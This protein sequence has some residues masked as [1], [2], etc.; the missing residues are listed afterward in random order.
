MNGQQF[1]TK[2]QGLIDGM[3]STPE[4][5][6]DFLTLQG[7]WGFRRDTSRCPIA[8]YITRNIGMTVNV[9]TGIAPEMR[10]WQSDED[11]PEVNLTPAM[12]GF[13]GAFDRGLYPILDV[14]SRDCDYLG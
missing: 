12:A 10:A 11:A 14:I 9:C 2:V 6:R 4:E 5:I 1:V 3:G 13:I 7:C 8:T